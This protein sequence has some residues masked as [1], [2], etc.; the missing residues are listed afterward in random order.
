MSRWFL[1]LIPMVGA[2]QLA[3]S[4]ARAG[5]S[6]VLEDYGKGAPV[7]VRVPTPVPGRDL[8]PPSGSQ[9]QRKAVDWLLR[10]QHSDGGW[11][12]G[13]HGADGLS[14]ASDVATTSYSVLALIRD[15]NGSARHADPIRRGTMFVVE[16]VRNAPDGPRLR[17]PEGTQIQYKLGALADT[18]FAGLMLGE[19]VGKTDAETSRAARSALDVVVSK[20]AMA[21]QADGS[22]DNNGWAP[23]LSTS[24]AAATLDKAVALGIRVDEDVM[25]KS[26][27][28]QA[29]NAAPSGFDASKGAGVQLYAVATALAS[30][31]KTATR[32]GET[33]AA[34]PMKQLAMEAEG[35]ARAAVSGDSS[36]ALVAGFGSVG[37]EEVLSYM[38]ISDTLAQK[39]GTEWTS[40]NGR[41][42]TLL[43][44][45][46]NADG[47]WAGHHCITSR[48]FATAGAVMTL[49]A[50]DYARLTR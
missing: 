19:V 49:A 38:M 29:A 21:Q 31:A 13:S 23:V 30:N 1:L 25:N 20:V 42:G 47:S 16:A 28:Y 14:S 36:G 5:D 34:A 35:R 32:G 12:S 9:S 37:G 8:P 11:S 46:Q 26:D 40:W 4:E 18:H 44:N 6:A 2:L 27:A 22:F 39:G 7:E 48:A 50:G 24:V 3:R 45:A 17:T 10:Q 41:I 33:A 15:A 43:S